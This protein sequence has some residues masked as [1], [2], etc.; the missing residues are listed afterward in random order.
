MTT[1]LNGWQYPSPKLRTFDVPGANRRL[2]LDATA[3]P[4]LV[5]VAA[6]YDATV[7]RI[8]IGQTDEGGYCDRDARQ[9]GGRKSNHA[10]GTAIDLNWSEEG[11]LNSSWGKRFFADVKHKA[12]MAVILKRYGSCIAWGGN[13][14]SSRTRDYMHFEIK[15]GTSRADVQRLIAKLGIDKNGKR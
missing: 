7:R 1:S 13:A 15:P 12:A 4:L 8:D 11:A 5:A 10:N 2:T 9:G 3:G 6:D 14:W